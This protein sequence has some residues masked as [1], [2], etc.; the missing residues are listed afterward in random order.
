MCPPPVPIGCNVRCL[1]PAQAENRAAQKIP[2]AWQRF[3]AA[4]RHEGTIWADAKEGEG[5]TFFFSVKE[6]EHGADEQDHPAG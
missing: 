2:A 3:L 1:E 4:S 5:A 6:A